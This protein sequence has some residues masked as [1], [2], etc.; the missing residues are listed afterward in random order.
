MVRRI[1]ESNTELTAIEKVRKEL[2]DS[3]KDEF[4]AVQNQPM[5]EDIQEQIQNLRIEMNTA[6][7]K[8]A[9]EAAKPFLE[10]ILRLESEYALFLKLSA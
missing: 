8:A 2:K 4:A 7:R 1:R 10:Q 3:G 5:L 6:K 9:D